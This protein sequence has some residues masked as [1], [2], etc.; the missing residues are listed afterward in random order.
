MGF[1]F[2]QTKQFSKSVSCWEALLKQKWPSEV[3]IKLRMNRARAS[4][5]AAQIESQEGRYE[6]AAR[7]LEIYCEMYPGDASGKSLSAKLQRLASLKEGISGM[8]SAKRFIEAGQWSEAADQ[9][10][11]VRR[12]VG[13]IRD[14]FSASGV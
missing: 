11:A 9:L 8:E 10:L 2:F 1:A 3:E 13:Q 6:N 5:M 12:R 4:Y 7:L 14:P